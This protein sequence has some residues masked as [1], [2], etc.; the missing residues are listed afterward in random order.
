[1]D[2]KTLLSPRQ[3]GDFSPYGQVLDFVV[4]NPFLKLLIFSSHRIKHLVN[5]RQLKIMTVTPDATNHAYC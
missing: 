1:M 3:R 5:G 4:L 2:L